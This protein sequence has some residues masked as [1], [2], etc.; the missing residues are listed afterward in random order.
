MHIPH[1]KMRIFQRR[2]FPL[3]YVYIFKHG[4][5]IVEALL[6][7][8]SGNKVLRTAPSGSYRVEF[9]VFVIKVNFSTTMKVVPLEWKKLRT[10]SVGWHYLKVSTRYKILC[11]IGSYPGSFPHN[12]LTRKN[13]VTRLWFGPICIWWHHHCSTAMMSSWSWVGHNNRTSLT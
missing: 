2:V 11:I 13:Q 8:W 1:F 6:Q 12:A 5:F 4:C 3:C 7:Q 9:T 10:Y